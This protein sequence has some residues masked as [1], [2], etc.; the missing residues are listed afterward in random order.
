MLKEIE[1]NV[2]AGN[3]FAIETTLSGK[4]T[5]KILL[6]G[7]NLAITSRLLS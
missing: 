2:K 6:H 4:P 7:K 1:L 5:P 3:S